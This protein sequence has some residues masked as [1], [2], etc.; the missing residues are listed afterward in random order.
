M[1]LSQ[2]EVRGTRSRP[3]QGNE[4][5]QLGHIE[6]DGDA[7][8]DASNRDVYQYVE[9]RGHCMLLSQHSEMPQLCGISIRR[10]EAPQALLS[11]RRYKS[12]LRG[13]IR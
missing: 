12:Q 1:P 8:C 3:C 13:I 10:S 2:D 11:Q 6:D 4:Q 5:S 7:T 9:V